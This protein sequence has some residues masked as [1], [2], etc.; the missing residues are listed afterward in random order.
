MSPSRLWSRSGRIKIA[1]WRFLD[2]V[3]P[4]PGLGGPSPRV[5]TLSPA[6]IERVEQILS[7]KFSPRAATEPQEPIAYC[8][9]E[10]V[11]ME[12]KPGETYTGYCEAC[13]KC[14]R[15]VQVPQ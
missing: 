1:W 7:R 13:L 9:H 15:I 4:R 14:G 2:R 3:N 5:R 6:E 11:Y 10:W 8:N 12:R